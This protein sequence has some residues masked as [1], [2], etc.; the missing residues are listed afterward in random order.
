MVTA[1]QNVRAVWPSRLVRDALTHPPPLA[2][3]R[4]RRSDLLVR[5]ERQH[6]AGLS[7]P[8]CSPGHPTRKLTPAGR[9]GLLTP[10]SFRFAGYCRPACM[11]AMHKPQQSGVP[12]NH[13]S[14]DMAR[15]LPSL[16]VT[17]S[18]TPEE[19]IP[20]DCAFGNRNPPSWLEVNSRL[21]LLSRIWISEVQNLD[22]P[23]TGQSTPPFPF[24]PPPP[25]TLSSPRSELT[26]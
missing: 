10:N 2:L 3:W 11:S 21:V 5:H 20:R 12:T 13:T 26:G 6:A 19:G 22:T 4:T 7:N 18:S 1:L 24:S 17:H 16:V 14:N 23:S 9:C 8:C 15:Q 25:P